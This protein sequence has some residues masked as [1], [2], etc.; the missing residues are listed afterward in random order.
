MDSFFLSGYHIER[1]LGRERGEF[2]ISLDLGVSKGSIR[3]YDD[4]IEMPDGQDVMIETLS[5]LHKRRSRNDCFMI[6]DGDIKWLYAF[7]GN[8]TY[9]LYEPKMDW[10]TTIE[11]NGSFMHTISTS[12][13]K[14]EANAKVSA[15]GKVKGEALDT[16]FGLGYTSALL[17]EGG[18]SGVLSYE[19]SDTVLELARVN[20]WSSGA[21]D[22]KIHVAM[23]DVAEEIHNL[24]SSRFDAVLHDPPTL[25]STTKLYSGEFY[26]EMYRVLKPGGVL[27]HFIGTKVQNPKHNYRRGIISRLRQCGFSVKDAYRGVRAEKPA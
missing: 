16:V 21:F 15:L 18:A 10:P 12:T 2:A 11:I 27:Y 8:S 3:I 7:E 23:G 1:I 13:P 6:A 17:N 19:I 26:R 22:S 24:E 25:Q 14:Q 20:P 5:K 9:K 4:R